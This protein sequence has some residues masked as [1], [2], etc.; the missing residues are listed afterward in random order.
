MKIQNL[1]QLIEWWISEYTSD[2]SPIAVSLNK[3]LNDYENLQIENAKLKLQL[4][5]L[6]EKLA[7]LATANSKLVFKESKNEN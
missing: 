2:D 6:R 3:Q 5:V 7:T 1:K 4:T